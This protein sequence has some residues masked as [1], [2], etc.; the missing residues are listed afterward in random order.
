MTN[1]YNLLIPNTALPTLPSSL[2]LTLTPGMLW[3]I[4]AV[5]VLVS[6]VAAIT[7]LYHW[8]RYSTG[9]GHMALAG[10]IFLLGAGSLLCGMFIAL[11][12]YQLSVMP[13][14]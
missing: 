8:I 4:L 12:Y 11:S 14:F 2:T 10:M 7:L 6:I 9:P 1:N 3:I 5:V 13:T